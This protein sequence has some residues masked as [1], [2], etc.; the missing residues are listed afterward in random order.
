MWILNLRQDK[1]SDNL[2]N[3][4]CVMV[5]IDSFGKC[6][7]LKKCSTIWMLNM[8]NWNYKELNWTERSY[9]SKQSELGA[10]A[11]VGK[12]SK[13]LTMD[14]LFESSDKWCYVTPSEWY[15]FLFSLS[16][17]SLLLPPQPLPLS[18]LLVEST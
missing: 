18:F 16:I 10:D 3:L 8:R 9:V 12:W 1:L 13:S 15:I 14:K 5:C 4:M 17:I 11:R 2:K 6:F 7:G